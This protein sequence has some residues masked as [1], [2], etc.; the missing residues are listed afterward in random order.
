MNLLRHTLY[1]IVLICVA[2]LLIVAVPQIAVGLALAF[3]TPVWFFFTAVTSFLVPDG[4]EGCDI[5]PF[6]FVPVF[7]PRPPPIS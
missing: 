1:L 5:R 3:L 4:N 7:S 6:P 2:A